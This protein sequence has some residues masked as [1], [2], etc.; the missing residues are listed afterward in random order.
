MQ[1]MNKCVAGKW[2]VSKADSK[3]NRIDEQ[4]QLAGPFDDLRQAKEWMADMGC[5]DVYA[6]R[7]PDETE[8]L[9]HE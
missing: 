6:W 3:A 1:T 9:C 7:S 4:K 5:N 2:Y 8:V